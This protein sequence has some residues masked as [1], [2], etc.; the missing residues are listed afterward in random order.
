MSTKRK[1]TLH[2]PAIGRRILEARTQAGISQRRLAAGTL[3]TAAYIS[4]IENGERTPNV[5]VIRDCAE[6]L[7]CSAAWLETG[8]AVVDVRLTVTRA[9][10]LLEH[11]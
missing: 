8:H 7:G 9:A 3:I 4:R 11:T 6:V 1:C 10:Q 5:R 2:D